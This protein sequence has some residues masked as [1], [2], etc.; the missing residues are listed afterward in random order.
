MC[1]AVGGVA[2][3]L[4]KSDVVD[5]VETIHSSYSAIFKS[6]TGCLK[7]STFKDF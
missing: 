5:Q 2:G 6:Y 7:K 1:P 3:R 4:C